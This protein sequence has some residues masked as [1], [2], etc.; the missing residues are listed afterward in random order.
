[1]PAGYVY[2]VRYMFLSMGRLNGSPGR[3][4]VNFQI[5]EAGSPQFLTKIPMD[6]TN[7][8]PMD[9]EIAGQVWPAGTDLRITCDE[10]SDSNTSITGKWIYDLIEV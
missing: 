1:M 7:G 10:V 3:A 8:I 2:R 6:L 5:R 9:R 4:R